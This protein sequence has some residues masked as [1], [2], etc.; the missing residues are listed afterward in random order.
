MNTLI[1]IGTHIPIS[2]GKHIVVKEFI[3]GGGQGEVYKVY[4]EGI[5]ELALKW[6]FSRNQ[7][8]KLKD[9]LE[10]LIPKKPSEN[11]LWPKRVVE[12]KGSFG[13][14][15]DLRPQNYKKSHKL[16][17]REFSLSY[18]TACNVCLSL[19]DSFR[20]LHVKGLSYQ[21]I[22]FG[23]IFI[24]P[25]EG[26]I[27]I[28]DNDN[29]APH[30]D[31]TTGVSGTYGFM[32]PEVVLNTQKPDQYS[33]LF[34]LACLLFQI[35]F[36]EHP[37]NGRRWAS[38]SC[39][40]NFAKKKLYGTDPI[41]IFDPVNKENRPMPGVQDNAKLFWSM[42]PKYVREHFTTVFTKGLKNRENGRLLEEDWLEVFRTLRE[43]IIF[44]SNCGREIIY[45]KNY[46]KN[47]SCWGKNCGAEIS[48][49]PRLKIKIGKR[50]RTIVLNHNT[51]IYN[52]Q[53]IGHEPDLLKGDVIV[54]EVASNPENPSKWGIRNLTSTLWSYTKDGKTKED[55][56]PGKAF[57]LSKGI[58]IDF[59]TAE[60]E[61]I[62]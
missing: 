50:E 51:V 49:P 37:L 16:I 11:F 22:S 56:P 34:S 25:R 27:L 55:L 31:T 29:I 38:I 10:K 43:S 60:G 35:L 59:K 7:K 52:Y 44:C 3:G 46:D 36:L 40:D 20:K 39:W 18:S 53:L 32:A 30:G 23:N 48:P 45:E 21:D 61:I 17:E 5:G 13:Y 4:E 26:K 54:G 41:F 24:E 28:C 42:Y 57:V 58:K 19:V 14:L 33:D 12:Y 8:E 2:G 6:Y 62:Q 47:I 15:M 1:K 9:N